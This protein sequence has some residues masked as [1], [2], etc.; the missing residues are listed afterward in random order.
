MPGRGSAAGTS[1]VVISP[2]ARE[3]RT[4][5][6]VSHTNPTRLFAVGDRPAPGPSSSCLPGRWTGMHHNLGS[7]R[8]AGSGWQRGSRSEE[9]GHLTAFSGTGADLMGASAN[10]PGATGPSPAP[11]PAGSQ[12]AHLT[13]TCTFASPATDPL[14]RVGLIEQSNRARSGSP[15]PESIRP[16]GD[17]PARLTTQGESL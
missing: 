10:P 14:S 8:V 9:R 2:A 12:P 1:P 13:F 11:L 17:L 16:T 5:A 3:R 15:P 4:C 7:V 6:F